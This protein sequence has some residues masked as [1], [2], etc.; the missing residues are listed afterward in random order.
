ME[1]IEVDRFVQSL[2]H[3]YANLKLVMDKEPLIDRALLLLSMATAVNCMDWSEPRKTLD[4][5]KD[6]VRSVTGYAV[7]FIDRW[8]PEGRFVFYNEEVAQEDWNKLFM[9]SQAIADEL[10]RA[11]MDAFGSDT[12]EK[13][14]HAYNETIFCLT[15]MLSTGCARCIKPDDA[16][17]YVVNNLD[18][19]FDFIEKNCKR[20]EMD[21]VKE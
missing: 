15:Y 13:I 17:D 20:V 12:D 1:G 10:L 4:A 19:V 18:R 5:C 9:D 7:Q 2:E 8:A 16:V 21:P 3:E 14:L 6:S 11:H